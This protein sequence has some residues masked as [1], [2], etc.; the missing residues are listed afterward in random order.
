[1]ALH[2]EVLNTT[3]RSARWPTVIYKAIEALNLKFSG[4]INE[5]TINPFPEQYFTCGV[6]CESC[7]QRCDQSMG[8]A[9]E[10]KPHRNASPCRY[11]HQFENKVLL[12][13]QCHTNGRE[14]S[15]QTIIN[16]R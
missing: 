15:K 3:V 7:Q 1:M 9:M 10:G 11:Q 12:C 16:D 8:H 13:K 2:K 6:H 5:R 14:V 4:T